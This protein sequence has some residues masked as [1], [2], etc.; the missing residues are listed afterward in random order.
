VLCCLFVCYNLIAATLLHLLP[1][2]SLLLLP[3]IVPL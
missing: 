2:I 3:C 1:F